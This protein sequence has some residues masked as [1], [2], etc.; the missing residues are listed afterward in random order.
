MQHM[1]VGRILFCYFVRMHAYMPAWLL[2]C[3]GAYVCTPTHTY[4]PLQPKQC[5]DVVLWSEL[6]VV[7]FAF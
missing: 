7:P 2:A 4:T 5:A 3:R 6:Q 1:H